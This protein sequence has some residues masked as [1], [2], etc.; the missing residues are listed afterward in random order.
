MYEG[1]TVAGGA[2]LRQNPAIDTNMLSW[3]IATMWHVTFSSGVYK[4]LHPVFFWGCRQICY[5]Q[6]DEHL[7]SK[8]SWVPANRL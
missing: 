1:L 7:A 6:Q 4:E 5:L 3:S 2:S 8:F